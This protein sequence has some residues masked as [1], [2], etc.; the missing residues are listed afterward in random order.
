MREEELTMSS[1]TATAVIRTGR[2]IVNAPWKHMCAV[3]SATEVG[4]SQD[5]GGRGQR[6][7]ARAS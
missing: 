7:G 3:A 5:W 4:E 2:L 1:A 6:Y